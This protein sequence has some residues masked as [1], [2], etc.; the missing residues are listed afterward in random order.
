VGLSMSVLWDE[1][2]KYIKGQLPEKSYSLWINP[3]SLIDEREDA[4]VL[5]CPNKFSMNWIMDHYGRL[6]ENSLRDMGKNHNIIYKVASLV[7]K[8]KEP[9]I[10]QNPPQLNIPN[11]SPKKAR[12]KF[13]FNKEFTFDRFVVGTCNEFAYSAS[14][15]I[16]SGDGC[17]Y[18]SLFM[19]ATTGLGKSHLSQSIGHMLL[20]NNPDVRAYYITAEDFVNEMIFALK[21]NRIEEFK[22]KYRRSCDVLMLEEVHFLS[23]KEKIQTELG[24]TLD[25]LANDNK[26]LIFTSSMLPKDIPNMSKELSSRLTSGLITTLEKPDYSTRLKI[27][28]KKA[29]EYQLQLSEEIVHLFAEKL[30]KDIRQI[31]SV[32]RCFKAKTELMKAKI[33]INLAKEILNYHITDQ[34]SISLDN[35]KNLICKYYKIENSVLPSKSRKKIHTYPR[36]MYV[37]LSRNYSEAT[38]EEIG[39]SINRNHSTIIY[40]SEVIEKKIKLDKKVKNQVD[41]LSQKIKDLGC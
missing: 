14:R 29:S 37:Y 4:L 3:L 23:G 2:K 11:I 22:N 13:N 19:R 30:T 1:L 27:I 38:L 36:N 40:S 33:D 7:R 16:A 21:T 6:L 32:L 28:E 26:K 39:K 9:V 34:S 25:A 20:E 24:Y 5:G 8:N 15:A 35:I 17:S 31:E 10:F 18:D 12:G 41:F